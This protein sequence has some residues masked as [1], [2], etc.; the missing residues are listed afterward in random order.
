LPLPYYSRDKVFRSVRLQLVLSYLLVGLVAALAVGLVTLLIARS[1]FRQQE[2]DFLTRNAD[3]IARDV[4]PI[5]EETKSQPQEIARSKLWASALDAE[6]QLELAAQ[7]YSFLGQERVTIFDGHGNLL[8]D[9]GQVSAQLVQLSPSLL[10]T[11]NTL[12]VIASREGNVTPIQSQHL[13]RIQPGPPG[14]GFL[15]SDLAGGDTRN[16]SADSDSDLPSETEALS[17]LVVRVPVLARDGAE[18]GYIQLSEGPAYGRP[19]LRGIENALFAGVGA[20]VALAIAAGL[21]SARYVTRPLAALGAAAEQMAAGE[22][23]ARAPNRRRDEFGQLARQFNQMAEQL[24]TTVAQLAADREALRRFIADASHELRTPLTALKAFGQIWTSS[25]R[26]RDQ[27]EAAMWRASSEQIDRLDA[28][29]QGLLDLSR[30]DADLPEGE[31][32][33]DDV[34]PLLERSRLAFE[35]LMAKKG[36]A[37][38][39]MLPDAPVV[40]R[41]DATF[42]QRAV[43]NL[44]GNA[45]KFAPAGGRV[46]VGL[47]VDGEWVRIRV[48]DSGPGISE[49]ELPYIFERFYRGRGSA[50]TEGSGLG[51]AIVKA[52]AETHGGHVTVECTD[53]CC[54]TVYLPAGA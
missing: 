17:D 34:R 51:L 6:Q 47:D 36:L 1:H 16:D 4:R 18:T 46:Q 2:I 8:A 12:T 20:A 43:D 50:G 28:L 44:L 41:H 25:P 42:L 15:L 45:L 7:Y 23:S 26:M 54:F 32:V 10:E 38:E 22:L 40:V 48:R 31:F 5:L 11:V 19:I 35:P 24:E 13:F 39:V 37:F 33:P 49:D 3:A 52:V 29:T 30:L 14:G 27:P 53:G 21:L 9:S